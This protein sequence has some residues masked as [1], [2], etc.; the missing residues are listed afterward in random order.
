MLNDTNLGTVRPSSE[1][2]TSLGRRRKMHLNCKGKV[3]R[4]D[5][6]TCDTCASGTSAESYVLKSASK[7]ERLK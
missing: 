1:Q 7:D 6:A 4:G 2:P 3:G 5:C